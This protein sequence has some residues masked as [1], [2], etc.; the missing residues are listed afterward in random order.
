M[1]AEERDSNA[2]ITP[3]RGRPPGEQT[4]E[5]MIRAELLAH[6]RIYKRLR[7]KVEQRLEMGELDTEELAKLMELVR[8]G[9]VEMAKPII[10]P[11][12]SEVAKPHEA[13]ED[14]AAILAK[15][16]GG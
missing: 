6:L 9:I 8:K 10:A 3:K 16:I 2:P 15:L 1:A 14:A 5:G 13:E 12:K 11:A 7:E 4:P